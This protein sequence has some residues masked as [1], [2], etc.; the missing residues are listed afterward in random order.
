MGSLWELMTL[1]I[2]IRKR[3][4]RATSQLSLVLARTARPRLRRCIGPQVRK[5]YEVYSYRHAASILKHGHSSELADIAKAL[6]QFRI[7]REEIRAPGGS[8]TSMVK[9][10]TGLLRRAGWQETRIFADLKVTKVTKKEI[11]RET[12][13]GSTRTERITEETTIDNPNF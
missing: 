2:V 1:K 3:T 13:S 6:C 5:L 11:S 9:R 10:V 8:E 4:K 7:S 12:K